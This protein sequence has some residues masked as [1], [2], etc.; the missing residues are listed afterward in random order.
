MIG[1][2]FLKKEIV[3]WV[4][5][6]TIT[7]EQAL[8]ILGRYDLKYDESE[9]NFSILSILGYL[10]LGVALIVLIANNWN[11]IPAFIKVFALIVITSVTHIIAYKNSI[12]QQKS[13]FFFLANLFYGAS[14]ILIAQIYHLSTYMPNGVLLWAI[15]SFLVAIFVNNKWVNLQ[16][17][18]IAMIWAFMEIEGFYP[19]LFWVFLLVVIHILYKQEK[20]RALFV[21]FVLNLLWFI[22]Y[23]LYYFT[24][25]YYLVNAKM[26]YSYELELYVLFFILSA[27]LI[28]LFL[29]FTLSKFE[30]KYLQT[31]N[32]MFITLAYMSSFL[33]LFEDVCLSLIKTFDLNSNVIFYPLIGCILLLAFLL[34]QKKFYISTA[35]FLFLIFVFMI[36]SS[37]YYGYIFIA[38]NF[39]IFL[40]YSYVIYHSIIESNLGSYR[41]GVA[42]VLIFIC[43]HYYNLISQDYI[44]TAI[45]FFVC[46]MFLL[47][48]VKFFKKIKRA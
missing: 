31:T 45:F 16:A 48:S 2:M 35:I 34:N 42:S 27:Y 7:K 13:N 8:S 6:A 22:P 18:I 28:Y 19:Y 11:E 36:T 1:K 24:K 26:F 20:N 44:S 29:N 21:L 17:L 43:T 9:K 47:I 37:E 41:L 33:F 40:F 4:E 15:G 5:D 30:N 39:L 14:I 10:F 23:T 25:E 46:A 12:N 32:S 3:K 38:M